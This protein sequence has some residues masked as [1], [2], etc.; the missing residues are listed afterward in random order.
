IYTRPDLSSTVIGDDGERVS[1]V[2]E[3]EAYNKDTGVYYV[4]IDR[5]LIDAS[6]G[7]TVVLFKDSVIFKNSSRDD[8]PIISG[9]DV[10]LNLNGFTL[11]WQYSVWLQGA[12]NLTVENG[13]IKGVNE[14]Q[15][16]SCF[17]GDEEKTTVTLY[18]LTCVGGFNFYNTNATLISCNVTLNSGY[19]VIWADENSNV[20]VISGKYDATARTVGQGVIG[21]DKDAF[22]TVKGGTF[23]SNDENILLTTTETS[24]T[25]EYEA[26]SRGIFI[27][28]GSFNVN[29][30]DFTFK[31]LKSKNPENYEIKE[32]YNILRNGYVVEKDGELWTVKEK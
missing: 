8:C 26:D 20:T 32:H 29:V 11:K 22:I 12:E 14:N 5:A 27:Q 4:G 7:E 16:Y 28:G 1:G 30:S 6:D 10:T 13:F 18:N 15:S 31:K 21:C 25:G 9:K 23:I 2:A 3:A 19:N 17:F 24:M